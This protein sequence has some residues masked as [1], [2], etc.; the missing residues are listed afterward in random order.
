MIQTKSCKADPVAIEQQ[1]K[2]VV[3]LL[4]TTR[5]R[6]GLTLFEYNKLTGELN[7]AAFTEEK[8]HV[9]DF[10]AKN[11][12][13]PTMRSKVVIKEHC[14]YFQALNMANASKKLINAGCTRIV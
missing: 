2:K 3:E 7:K 9:A 1:E 5:K 10:S 12:E 4:G 13:K 11:P 8:V 6:P 14:I